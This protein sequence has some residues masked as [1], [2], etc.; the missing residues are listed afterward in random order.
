MPG[1]LSPGTAKPSRI[2][3]DATP[4]NHAKRNAPMMPPTKRSGTKIVKCHRAMP[5]MDQ[6]KTLMTLRIGGGGARDDGVGAPCE[7][8][9][10]GGIVDGDADPVRLRHDGSR[11]VRGVL[12]RP[13]GTADR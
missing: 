4:P 7:G 3:P 5:T 8:R 2:Q 12:R 10:R 1:G 6:T 13:S 11:P 9:P